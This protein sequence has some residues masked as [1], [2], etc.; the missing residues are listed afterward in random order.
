MIPIATPFPTW[1]K[2]QRVSKNNHHRSTPPKS[3]RSPHPIIP[4]P[5]IRLCGI[6]Y[7]PLVREVIYSRTWC[8]AAR[9]VDDGC[10]E[11]WQPEINACCKGWK[12]GD[13]F[14]RTK[15][16]R[17]RQAGN[18][19]TVHRSSGKSVA[20]MPV[21][22]WFAAVSSSTSYTL[23]AFC[24]LVVVATTDSSTW[25]VETSCINKPNSL[26]VDECHG[27]WNKKTTRISA[28][29]IS[30]QK[31]WGN[32]SRLPPVCS[33]VTSSSNLRLSSWC[34]SMPWGKLNWRKMGGSGAANKK[35]VQRLCKVRIAPTRDSLCVSWK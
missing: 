9:N 12:N 33:E 23:R 17:D 14:V 10:K 26:N 22:T 5:P 8:N 31:V 24:L 7:G 32:V 20:Y 13:S 25:I 16:I 11:D 35:Y 15:Y 1:S 2:I 34:G 6:L 30:S 27:S 28:L 3:S 4:F 21:V 18:R 19:A 29:L